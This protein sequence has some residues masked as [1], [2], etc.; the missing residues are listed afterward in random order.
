MVSYLNFVVIG[1]LI[2]LFVFLFLR[3]RRARNA[4]VK[5]VGLI[6]TGLLTVLLAVVF[7]GG[8]VGA[9]RLNAKH[10]NPVAEVQVAMTPEQIAHGER[11]AS[12]CLGCHSTDGEL[13]LEGQNFLGGAEGSPPVGTV[14]APNLTP[15]HFSDWTDGEIIRAIREGVH[16][17]GRSLIIMPSKAF[18][19]MSDEDVQAL[20]AYLR[21]QPA[22]EPDTPANRLNLLG[23]A[24]TL[25][26]PL[27]SA[28]PSITQPVV[29][30]PAGPTA[31][32]GAY[33][34]SFVGC[35]DC[36]GEK[37][38]GDTTG[39]DPNAPAGPN[40]TR[41]VP[42]WTEEQFVSFF[43]TGVDPGGDSVDEGMPWQDYDAFASDDDLR[44]MFA[45]LSTLPPSGQ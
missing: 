22:V 41:I 1:A 29:A 45:Y 25:M 11:I 37:L 35:S 17:S 20:V 26:A 24:F 2:A 23:V 16:K 5:W 8:L 40:L 42:T 3:A 36:H 39:G 10:D 38:D 34:T 4:I 14:Y 30:P 7:V 19:N 33:L 43:R 28:R 44:A 21:S 31:A 27:A 9:M 18:H 12:L 6:L 32:Y 13:P 15:A